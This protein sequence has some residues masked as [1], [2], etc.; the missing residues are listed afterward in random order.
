MLHIGFDDVVVAGVVVPPNA[1]QDRTLRNYP[2]GLLQ[3]Q[4]QNIELAGCEVDGAPGAAYLARIRIQLQVGK[5]ERSAEVI[6][7]PPQDSAHPGDE[8]VEIE[9]FDQ[10]IVGAAL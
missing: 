8:F 6:A 9:R 10:V 5:S 4:A 1:L 7:A 3:Q 2:A